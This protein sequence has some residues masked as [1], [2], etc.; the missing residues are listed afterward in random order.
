MSAGWS[1]RRFSFLLCQSVVSLDEDL[2][3]LLCKILRYELRVVF[4]DLTNPVKTTTNSFYTAGK[5]LIFL[6]WSS[7]YG[8]D[9]LSFTPNSTLFC[10]IQMF[11]KKII[12]LHEQQKDG[13]KQS[14]ASCDVALCFICSVRCFS[15]SLDRVERRASPSGGM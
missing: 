15:P 14:Y 8:K 13:E 12:C 9:L 3:S 7:R 4:F 1:V 11:E 6:W 5:K 10:R 2:L